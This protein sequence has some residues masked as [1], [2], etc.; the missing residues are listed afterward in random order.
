MTPYEPRR[1][2]EIYSPNSVEG[3]FLEIRVLRRSAK[4]VCRALSEARQKLQKIRNL[5]DVTPVACSLRLRP[6]LIGQANVS[7]EETPR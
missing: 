3:V 1:T 2:Q 4:F 7:R 6:R 5:S